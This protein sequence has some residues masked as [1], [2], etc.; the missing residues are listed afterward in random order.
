[1]VPIINS[2]IPEKRE[3]DPEKKTDMEFVKCFTR[4]RFPTFF[5]LTEKNELITTFVCSRSNLIDL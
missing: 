5:I 3:V 1:M 4:A 2:D